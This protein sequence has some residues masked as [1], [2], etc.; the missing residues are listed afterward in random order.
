VVAIA[1]A[2]SLTLEWSQ[3]YSRSRFPSLQDVLCDVLGASGG[4][5][6]LPAADRIVDS[7]GAIAV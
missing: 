2:L 3:L 1:G 4:A 7:L 6:S 5:C